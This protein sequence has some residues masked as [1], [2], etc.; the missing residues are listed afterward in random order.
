MVLEA[1]LFPPFTF[2]NLE[3]AKATVKYPPEGTTVNVYNPFPSS[4]IVLIEQP[5]KVKSLATGAVDNN[6]ALLN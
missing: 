3:A 2:V 1:T 6:S 4:V 5:L